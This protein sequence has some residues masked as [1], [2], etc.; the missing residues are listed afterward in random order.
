MA[1][2]SELKKYLCYEDGRLRWANELWR[3][4]TTT[5]FGAKLAGNLK[6]NGYWY[7]GFRG[8]RLLAHRVIFAMHYDW[9]PDEI[10]HIDGNSQNNKIENLRAA[11]SQINSK[12]IKKRTDNKTG[13]SGLS[14]LESGNWRLRIGKKHIGCYKN[15]NDAILA[16]KK[17]LSEN[18]YTER[19]GA[20]Q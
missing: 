14:K 4:G 17:Y 11:N 1:I 20:L 18:G 9:W 5:R 16:R 6:S 19:H 12:N 15:K 3:K 8:E 13:Y 2:I 7:I 10:D